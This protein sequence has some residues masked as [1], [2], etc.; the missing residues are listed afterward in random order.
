MNLFERIGVWRLRHEIRKTGDFKDQK[1]KLVQSVMPAF[2][3][4]NMPDFEVLYRKYIPDL[5]GEPEYVTIFGKK[6]FKKPCFLVKKDWVYTNLKYTYQF[7]EFHISHLPHAKCAMYG[8]IVEIKTKI[9]VTETTCPEN[10]WTCILEYLYSNGSQRGSLRN[11][12]LTLGKASMGVDDVDEE[13][14]NSP[15]YKS[16]MYFIVDRSYINPKYYPEYDEA[17]AY[18]NKNESP[19]MI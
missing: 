12:V 2:K 17:T 14:L 4:F 11:L 19:L 15:D 8:C 1:L 9:P 18:Y 6:L 7:S 3:V 5:D 13:E 10:Y 16:S